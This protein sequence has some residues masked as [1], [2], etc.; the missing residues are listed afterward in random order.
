MNRPND[1][2][3]ILRGENQINAITLGFVGN[4]PL[5]SYAA[6]REYGNI[7]NFE[8]VVLL[9]YEGNDLANLKKELESEI[10]TKYLI[11]RNFSQNLKSNQS[12]IDKVSKDLIDMQK[13]Y[14]V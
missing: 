11:D 4:G 9:Y 13:E 3:S 1:V 12:K 2:A 14:L 6:L 8:N 5:K 7:L 10:L